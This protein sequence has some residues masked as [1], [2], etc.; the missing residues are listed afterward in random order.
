MQ[1]CIWV[2]K[3]VQSLWK[4]LGNFFLTIQS[5]NFNTRYFY[6]Y[7]NIC[8]SFAIYSL[9]QKTTQV[10]TSWWMHK[11]IVVYS[12]NGIHLD[13]KKEW[14]TNSH[15]MDERSLEHKVRKERKRTKT[16]TK[17]Q[18]TQK[19][20]DCTTPFIWSS[21]T[22]KT[23]LWWQS[24]TVVGGWRMEDCF[25]RRRGDFLRCWKCSVF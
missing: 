7:V 13:H 14:G 19:G 9:R 5:N 25:G 4:R 21:T 22:G 8:W 12:Y 18:L 10:S 24:K 3:M 1:C 17:R 6:L 23:N 20:T 11:Q 16:T 15:H 2:C